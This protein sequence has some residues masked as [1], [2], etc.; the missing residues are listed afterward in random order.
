M[1]LTLPSS[2]LVTSSIAANINIKMA[3]S[4]DPD[5]T[6][7]YESSHLALHCFHRYMHRSAGTKGLIVFH[8]VAL[9]T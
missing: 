6:A 4:A 9:V 5:E 3:N 8:Y 7:R 1:K 2:N